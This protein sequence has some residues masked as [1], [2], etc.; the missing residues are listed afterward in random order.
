VVPCR[1]SSRHQFFPYGFS[2][3]SNQVA[4]VLIIFLTDEID[5]FGVNQGPIAGPRHGFGYLAVIHGHVDIEAAEAGRRIRSV[6]RASFEKKLPAC[7]ATNRPITGGFNHSV[8]RPSG[9]PSNRSGRQH[10]FGKFAPSKRSGVAGIELMQDDELGGV[11]KIFSVSGKPRPAGSWR[12][13][14]H[15]GVEEATSL[16]RL[17]T[18]SAAQA[19]R[20]GR[21]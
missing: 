14:V 6:T 5:H 21:L 10:I 1:N 2:P 17:L 8:S 15:V 12:H 9:R 18:R 19:G 16:A 7:R 20:E 13:A 4:D 11:W 3:A